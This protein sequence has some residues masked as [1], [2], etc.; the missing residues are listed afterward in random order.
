VASKIAPDTPYF[1]ASELETQDR[2][3]G[4]IDMMGARAAM[5]RSVKVSGNFIG[6]LHVALLNAPR[7]TS[8]ALIPTVDG[9]YIVAAERT[10]LTEFM[11]H[12]FRSLARAFVAEENRY[13]Q[14]VVRGGIA[15]GPVVLGSS[16]SK[17]ESAVLARPAH[18]G[19]R[20]AIL[21]GFPVVQAY[22][23]EASAPPFGVSVHE[24][25]RAFA[26]DTATPLRSSYWK[27]YDQT[28]SALFTNLKR[29]LKEYFSF[30]KFHEYEL[31][32]PTPERLRHE[33]LFAEY[34]WEA[35]DEHPKIRKPGS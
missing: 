34:F 19:Y 24:S 13:R 3:V 8:M 30:M 6:K 16:L 28:D 10:A 4:R 14:F 1:D 17:T 11:R 12:A 22:E 20:D 15:Y 32:Y 31:G 25:A 9:A 26:P 23:V 18:A 29:R 33:S 21:I 2:Y 5:T 35:E 27:W 7:T